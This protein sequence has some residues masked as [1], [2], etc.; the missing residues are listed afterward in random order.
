MLD[1]FG[2]IMLLFGYFSSGP[3]D[4][5]HHYVGFGVKY[6]HGTTGSSVVFTLSWDPTPIRY[7]APPEWLGYNPPYF[8][9]LSDGWNVWVYPPEYYSKELVLKHELN[10]VKQRRSVGLLGMLFAKSF[11]VNIEPPIGGS[12]TD[13]WS[14]QGDGFSLLRFEIPISV[15]TK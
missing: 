6:V 14:P 7:K 13:M 8:G 1:L 5:W 3:P 10:H 9:G 15:N 12:Y 2:L 11:G 4:N